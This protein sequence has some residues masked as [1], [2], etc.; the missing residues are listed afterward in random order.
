MNHLLKT[1]TLELNHN[2]FNMKSYNMKSSNMKSSN[3]KSSNIK[4]SNLKLL[5]MKYGPTIK[6]QDFHEDLFI[7]LNKY[8]SEID[9]IN[10]DTWNKYKS[11]V[12]NYEMIYSNK[13]TKNNVSTYLPISR[14]YFKLWEILNNFDLIDNKA[15][16]NLLCIAEGPGGFIE[17]IY[18]YRKK[19][20]N[21]DNSAMC[22]TLK[23]ENKTVP[24]W[25][26]ANHFLKYNPTIK[27][28]YGEDNTGNIY[29]VENIR[30]L[31]HKFKYRKANLVTAD[32]GFD[33]SSDYNNQEQTSYQLIMCEIISA[34]GCL[35]KNGHFIIKIFEI[36]TTFTVKILYFLTFFFEKVY[37]HKPLSSRNLNSEKYV[38]CKGFLG[39]HPNLLEELLTVIDEWNKLT[40]DNKYVSDIF[41]FNTPK[42]FN[43]LIQAYN[44]DYVKNNI[45][46]ILKTLTYINLNLSSKNVDSLK[47]HL[48]ILASLWCQKNDIGINYKIP[49][50]NKEYLTFHTYSQQ[51]Y[52][53]EENQ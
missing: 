51:S 53:T 17:A 44:V 38:I 22:M 50:L 5:N 48:Y 33:F 21:N 35:N 34:L 27:L 45:Y 30:F 32:G 23:S 41:N 12:N 37:I 26:K 14:A 49:L 8:K 1:K 28:S 52:L 6:N 24:S 16:L 11:Y 10:K 13:I 39:I 19:N 15:H 4:S 2:R 3:I 36:F 47:Q 7:I 46:N 20:N 31:I 18:N 29:H 42:E 25:S 40:L 43:E 9:N